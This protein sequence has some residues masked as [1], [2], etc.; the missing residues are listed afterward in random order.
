MGVGRKGRE[1]WR[2]EG[3]ERIGNEGYSKRLSAGVSRAPIIDSLACHHRL[4]GLLFPANRHQGATK[5]Q[6][7]SNQAFLF[8]PAPPAPPVP[9]CH[10]A[11][12]ETRRWLVRARSVYCKSVQRDYRVMGA[13]SGRGSDG[14]T[15]SQRSVEC[16]PELLAQITCLSAANG[17]R[18]T[19]VSSV[20]I[21]RLSSTMAIAVSSLA[22]SQHPYVI[23]RNESSLS[24]HTNT[25]SIQRCLH[26]SIMPKPMLLA[27][28]C[29]F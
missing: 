12:D 14:P 22:T 8:P 9:Q 4:P 7:R 10:R 27:C 26:P 17:E 24:L 15:Y 5:Q 28:H 6:P 13:I 16:L 21:A 19:N 1:R 29:A 20:I 3:R 23:T 11:T 18:T 25:E 2:R